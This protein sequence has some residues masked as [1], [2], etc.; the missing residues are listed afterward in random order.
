MYRSVLETYAAD[1][2]SKSLNIQNSFKA[3]NWKDYGT[4]VH[5]L[6]SASKAIGAKELS[7][8]AAG[9][10]AAA[11]AEDLS[12]INE[13]HD[14]VIL[15]YEKLA[16]LIKENSHPDGLKEHDGNVILEFTPG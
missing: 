8:L 9:L 1:A 7:E 3:M 6:K 15:M 4:Y 14:R 5:S 13:N 12:F 11:G 2:K 16:G 10:E